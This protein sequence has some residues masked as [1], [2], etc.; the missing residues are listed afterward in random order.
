MVAAATDPDV[1]DIATLERCLEIV[2]ELEPRSIARGT[3]WRIHTIL[4]TILFY[5][6]RHAEAL[7]H[8]QALLRHHPL[9]SD[10]SLSSML[11]IVW[12]AKISVLP[13]NR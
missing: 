12:G 2:H 4:S 9:T 1:P 5:L 11:D 7:P 6:G 10:R 8:A 13:A 3:E